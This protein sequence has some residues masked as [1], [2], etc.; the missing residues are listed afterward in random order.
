MTS[1]R[2]TKHFRIRSYETYKTY[3]EK[4]IILIIPKTPHHHHRFFILGE[5]ISQFMK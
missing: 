2:K 1:N 3:R 4:L 5:K